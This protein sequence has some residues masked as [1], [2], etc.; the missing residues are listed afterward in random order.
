M[1]KLGKKISA[2]ME[3]IS[4]AEAGEAKIAGEILN[5]ENSL[6]EK[7]KRLRQKVDLTLG[8]ID[9]LTF[10]ASAFSSAKEI[11]NAEKKMAEVNAKLESI[12]KICREI[13]K[14]ASSEDKSPCAAGE[15][16]KYHYN[17]YKYKEANNG[18]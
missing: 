17:Y 6:C 16:K 2:L 4:F 3:A 5:G 8:E 14:A 1:G 9:S 11:E 18:N 12:K 15:H 7:L 13:S 10:E